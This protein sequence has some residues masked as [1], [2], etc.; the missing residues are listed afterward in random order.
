MITM[1]SAMQH[2]CSKTAIIGVLLLL[3]TLLSGCGA[4]RFAYGQAPDLVYWWLDGHADFTEPQSERV[5]ADL[6]RFFDWH[7][8]TQLPDYAGLLSRAQ[9]QLRSPEPV[10]PEAVCRWSDEVAA[11]IT[12]MVE[13]ALPMA[14]ES[15]LQLAPW[16]LKH[17]AHKFDKVNAK[18]RDDY[19]QPDP[20]ERLDAAV[21]RTVD[22]TESLYGDIDDAQRERIARLVAASPFDPALWLAERQHRQQDLLNTLRSL[23]ARQASAG[24]AQAALRALVAHVQRSPREAYRAYE[25]RLRSYNC[26]VGA[27]VHNAMTPAQRQRAVERLK[28]WEDDLRALSGSR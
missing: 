9:A 10:T 8:R 25:A 14:A 12:P 4:L 22:R 1:S 2:P 20:A 16:Q 11:R 24:E 23:K 17:M 7:R 27:Q 3:T 5:R 6:G 26:M 21:E 13:E 15:V 19:L 28:G 18:F